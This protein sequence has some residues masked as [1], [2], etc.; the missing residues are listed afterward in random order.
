MRHSR[1]FLCT[2]TAIPLIA[3]IL[4]LLAP[5]DA[6][7][8]VTYTWTGAVNSAWNNTGNWTPATGFPLAVDNAVI[9]AAAGPVVLDSPRSVNNLT[10]STGAL[11]LNG[12]SLTV[13]GNGAFSGGTVNNGTLVFNSATGTCTFSGTTFGAIVQGNSANVYLNGSAFNA[14]VRLTKTGTSDNTC[15]GNNTFNSLVELSLASTANWYIANN[16]NDQYNGDLLVNNTSTGNLRFGWGTGGATLASGYTIAVGTGGFGSGR[17][18]LLDFVQLGTTAQNLSFSGS[19]EV[20]FRAGTVFNGALTVS[21]PHVYMDGGTYNGITSVTHTAST[22]SSGVGGCTFNDRLEL[23]CTGAGELRLCDTGTDLYNGD[24]VLTNSGGG[25]RFGNNGGVANLAAGRTISVGAGG[26]SAGLLLLKNFHQAGGTAQSLALTGT[27]IAYFRPGTSFDG[28][29]TVVAPRIMMDGGTYNAPTDLTTTSTTGSAGAGNCIF[30]S[31]LTVTSSGAGEFNFCDTG[32]DQYNGDILVNSPSGGGVRFG[33]N[34]GTALLAAGRTIGVGAGGFTS[35]LLLLR[36]FQQLGTTAQSIVLGGTSILYLR[37][38]TVFNADLDATAPRIAMDGG[39]YNGNTHLLMTGNTSTSGTGGCTFNGALDITT[40]GTGQIYLCNTNTD[41]YHAD[42]T[43]N[44]IGGG[45]VRFGDGGGTGILDAGRTI[46]V[47]SGGFNAGLLLI[48]GFQQLGTTP[49][50]LTLTGTADLYLR[51][52]TVFNG[53][54]DATAPRIMLDGGTYNDTAR[55]TMTGTSSAGGAGGCVFNSTVELTTA[56]AGQMQLHNANADQF[57]GDV[58]VNSLVGGGGITFGI[59][60]GSGTLAAGR[61]IAAGSAG[62]VSGSLQLKN[63]TQLG[64]T[65]QTILMGGSNAT[66]YFMTG[67]T[68]NGA[69]T[70]VTPRVAFDGATFN[71]PVNTTMTGAS[72]VNSNGGNAFNSTLDLTVTGSADLRL[73]VNNNDTF[74]DEVRVNSNGGAGIRFGTGS[75]SGTGTLAAGHTVAVGSGGFDAGV[76]LFDNFVQLGTT[77]QSLT[78]TGSSTLYIYGGTVFNADVTASA[79][80]VYLNGGLY[81]GQASFAK[82]GSG[83]D[84]SDGGNTFNGPLELTTT[85]PGEIRMHVYGDDQYNDDVTVTNPGGGGIR[86]GTGSSAGIGTLAAGH[87]LSV[88]SGGFTAGILSF[89]NFKQL[90]TTPH[91]LT[92]TGTSTL[93][94]YTGTEFNAPLTTVSPRLYLNGGTFQDLSKF[95][96]SGAVNDASTGGNT[97]NGPCEFTSTGSGELWLHATGSDAFNNDV[98]VNSTSTGGIRFGQNGGS[99]TLASGRTIAVGAAG[100][101]G[102]NLLFKNFTQ[103]GTAPSNTLLCTGAAALY[104]QSGNTFHAPLT[105]TSS[106]LFFNGTTFNGTLYCTK[107]G[108][109]T[110]VS[111]GGNTFNGATDLIVNGNG[112]L[113]L[114]NTL[115]D[116]FNDDLRVSCNG[117]GGIWLGLNS[118][119]ATL[120]SGHTISVGP[121][122]FTNGLLNLRNF[123]QLGGTAQS[124]VM[125]AGG[126]GTLQIRTGVTFNG[127]LTSDTPGLLLDGGTF[128]GTTSMTKRGTANNSSRGGNTFNATARLE[129]LG[130]GQLLLANVVADVFN[131]DAE[132]VRAGAGTMHVAYTANTTFMG[133]VSLVGS[134]GIIQ[135]GQNGGATIIGGSGD[136][137]FDGVVAFPPNVRHFRMNTSGGGRLFLNVT[138]DIYGATDFMNGEIHAASTTSTGNGIVRFASTCTFPTPANASSFVDGFVRKTGNTAFTFPVGDNGVYA[139]VSISAPANVTHHFTARYTNADPDPLYDDALK[140]ATIDHLSNCEYWIVDRTNGASNVSVT[141]GWDTPRSCGVTAPADLVVARWNGSQWK[142]HGNGSWTGTTTSGTVTTAAAVTAFSPFTLASRTSANPLP[143]ELLFF[144]AQAQGA[145]VPCSWSTATEL[146]N[147][148][149]EVERSRDGI[150]FATIGEVAGAGNSQVQLDYVFVDTDPLPGLSYYRLKQ[151]DLDGAL[152]WSAI[153]PV[154]R[155]TS[156][157]LTLYPN[158]ASDVVHLQPVANAAQPVSAMIHDGAGRMVRELE[159]GALS[160]PIDVSD[161]PAGAYSLRVTGIDGSVSEGRFLRQ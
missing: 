12:L 34:G 77:P 99:A 71:A 144:D 13:N 37:P 59:G 22:A 104:F 83:N 94:V 48:R 66:L 110:D 68:F 159:A 78:T 84:N 136:R 102:G 98:Q 115:A 138:M 32:T 46:T 45:G 5:G 67:T 61:T 14:A 128:N 114:G 15:T 54:L 121:G 56:G 97:F 125:G 113:Q 111:T 152:A 75:S 58:F 18:F 8:Q 63:F 135:F 2:C 148:H 89:N 92:T 123:T 129:N 64:A 36:G 87:L 100:F 122:G 133:D 6:S 147:D 131:D 69:V 72:A 35:G 9:P 51:S 124:I 134:T 82:T 49:Q 17:L 157:V 160:G 24:V 38:G 29:L 96:K 112:A 33:N 118:G 130:T 50:V 86:F 161:L 85:G 126:S 10:V 4:A 1:T 70:T 16:S 41:A 3:A 106:A 119:S 47:G 28:A 76:L 139:P 149:F 31:T 65:P 156:A 145:T 88:G 40:T 39:T 137:A 20:Y 151:V 117:T 150:D 81:Q 43:V 120:A 52:G 73:H 141:L 109:S 154:Q 21:A 60:G 142:D 101:T 44:N 53:T 26:Y 132:L 62:F 19:A 55:F 11:N 91:S 103:L 127:P 116:A 108:A 107:T 143:V 79:P 105:T 146:A 42:I 74:A 80:R 153:V 7:A 23:Y 30:N 57:N 158:P 95:T 155:S 27:A 93:I 25:I 90:G 140:D